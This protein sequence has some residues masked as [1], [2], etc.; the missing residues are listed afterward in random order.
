MAP[1]NV[2]VASVA[3][4]DVFYVTLMLAFFALYLYRQHVW[5]GIFIGLSALAKLYGALGAP[6]LLIHWLASRTKRSRWFALTIVLAPLSFVALMPLF[7]FAISHQFMN[8][9]M[10]IKDMLSLS[11]SLTFAN[12]THPS[13]S[14]PWAWRCGFGS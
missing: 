6:V 10:R 14:R 8:P 2:V 7:D 13:L 11:G 4:L 1:A 12:V 5:S 9:L 3:M